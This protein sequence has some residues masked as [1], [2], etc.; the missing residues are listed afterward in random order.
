MAIERELDKESHYTQINDFYESNPSVGLP[1]TYNT[2]FK[3]L[4]SVLQANLLA[5]PLSIQKAQMNQLLL[6]QANLVSINQVEDEETNFNNGIFGVLGHSHDIPQIRLWDLLNGIS[7]NDI[8]EIWK[9][10]YI[11]SKTSKSHYIVILKDVMLL[12]TCMFIVN[13]GMIC[14]H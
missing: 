4:D 2:I 5:I 7:Y 9:V 6:Y 1:S 11:T 3:E 8:T 12:C 13:Q 14:R 10:S